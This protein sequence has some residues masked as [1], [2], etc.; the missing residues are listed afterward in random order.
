M[1]QLQNP[2]KPWCDKI[3]Y[4]RTVHHVALPKILKFMKIKKS[5]YLEIERGEKTPTDVFLNR[6]AQF[7]NVPVEYILRSND[8]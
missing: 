1:G 8:L 5:T 2:D 4:L 7:Y 3:L 6:I